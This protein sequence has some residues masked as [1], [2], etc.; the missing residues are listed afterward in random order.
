MATARPGTRRGSASR[1]YRRSPERARRSV[2]VAPRGWPQGPHPPPSAAASPPKAYFSG[3]RSSREACRARQALPGALR[4]PASQS[5][6]GRRAGE[7][8]PQAKRGGGAERGDPGPC[9]W[10]SLGGCG[11]LRSRGAPSTH[12]A[13]HARPAHRAHHAHALANASTRRA[14]RGNTPPT[15]ILP[16]VPTSHPLHRPTSRRRT[17]PT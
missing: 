14:G 16:Q 6:S 4:G 1:G 12:P 2:A 5:C 3:I 8:R 13:C 7:V 10:G 9:A 15:R 17:P 11:R